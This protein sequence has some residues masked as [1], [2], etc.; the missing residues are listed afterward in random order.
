MKKSKQDKVRERENTQAP[1]IDAEATAV[2]LDFLGD[3]LGGYTFQTYDDDKVRNDKDRARTYIGTFEERRR[4]LVTENR[5]RFAVHVTINDTGGKSRR[6][7]NV[8]AVRKQFVEID[9]T[10]TLEEIHDIA[11]AAFLDIA[12]INESS[13]GKY[14]VYFNVAGDVAADLQGFKKRQK[15]LAALFDGGVES[16]DLPRVLRLPGFYHHK[17]NP[18]MVRT[19]YKDATARAHTI[20]D[21]DMAL[22]NIDDTATDTSGDTERGEDQMAINRA[23]EHFKTFP[24]AISNTKSGKMDKKGNNQTYDACCF[25]RDFGVEQSTCLDLI[26]EHYNPRCK[27][28]WSFEELERLVTNAYKYAQGKQG[29]KHP[30]ADAQKEFGADPIPEDF[31][32]YD[33]TQD[34]GSKMP[35]LH[36]IRADSVVPTIIDWL[37]FGHLALGQHTLFAGVQGDGKSQVIYSIIAAITTGGPWPGSNECAPIGNCVILSA[38]DTDKDVLVPRL[39]AAGADLSRVHII[40]ASV[41]E[42]GRRNKVLLQ[43]DM[44]LL[45]TTV[46]K[47]GDVKMISID[48]ISSYLGGD[49]DSHHNTELRDALDPIGTMAEAT[50][51]AVAS[52]THFNKA[53]KGVTAMNRIMGGVA[54]VAAPRAAFVILRDDENEA[55]R[56]MLPV[57]LNLASPDEAYGMAYEIEEVDTGATDARF[58]PPK[59]IRAPRVKWLEHVGKSADDVLAAREKPTGTSPLQDAMAW[60]LQRLAFDSALQSDIKEEI[61]GADL[62][63]WAT[64]RRAAKKLGV[65]SRK[66]PQRDG[67]GPYEWMLP[68]VAVDVGAD[69]D[70]SANAPEGYQGAAAPSDELQ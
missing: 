33:A 19:V 27:P 30:M 61:E 65:I 51:A 13:P 41:D 66:R 40:K 17:G 59:S 28:I 9:G 50:G 54:F 63:T 12:W 29:A 1:R 26:L 22:P 6:A 58:D 57:K 34:D 16:V 15:Q 39:M 42:H 7:A 8:I 31:E 44:K 2:F 56:L 25:A 60:L 55:R 24:P 35:Y 53:S 52:I 47:I 68:E 20:N 38:E 43:R 36:T 64:I 11:R 21:F 45:E 70:L 18:F 14:H 4:E 49:L 48:P 10:H 32:Q 69:P 62:H 46:K 5:D 67:R 3:A 23:I 37:W